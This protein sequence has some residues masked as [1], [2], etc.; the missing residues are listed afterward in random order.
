LAA[1]AHPE[2][3]RFVIRWKKLIPRCMD[4]QVLNI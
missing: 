4:E 1:G 3:F 2:A